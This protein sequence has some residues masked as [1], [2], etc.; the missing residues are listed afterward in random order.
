MCLLYNMMMY[1]CHRFQVALIGF[2]ADDGAV[3]RIQVL[4]LNHNL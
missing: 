4:S 3:N 1:P 2:K